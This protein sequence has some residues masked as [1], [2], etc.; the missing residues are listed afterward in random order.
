MHAGY[1]CRHTGVC[2]T[3]GWDI[4]ADWTLSATLAGHFGGSRGQLFA[5]SGSPAGP[6]VLARATGGA[7][8]LY[9]AGH[10]G[11]GCAAHRELGEAR[12]PSVCRHFPRVVLRDRRGLFVT[13][14]H[15]CP[16]AAAL[17]VDP[18][19]LRIVTAPAT[20]TLDGHAEG[21]EAS[22]VLPPLLRPGMLIDDE[23]HDA[24]ERAA[25]DVLNDDLAPEQALARIRASTT[26]L[27]DWT[28]NRGPLAD[29]VVHGFERASRH[30]PAVPLPGC[31]PD[32]DLWSAVADTIPEGLARPDPPGPSL[33]W[34]DMRAVW[35]DQAAGVRRYLAARLFAS[36][37]AYDAGG[38]LAAVRA[39]D[40][41]AAVLR[42][43]I[44]R[45]CSAPG[46]ATPRD[47]FLTGVRAADLLI[48]HLAEHR[49][50][51]R[52]VEQST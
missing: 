19:P 6:A 15:Y 3:S 40:I 12:L 42:V 25:V 30:S 7:C 8:I 9:D 29:A 11:G 51:C 50:L 23:G 45:A 28:P 2:C 22:G 16:T 48:V 14:S 5:R 1:R 38:L 26:A 33:D 43:E 24:W 34:V 44:S 36:W 37:F 21:L 39:V 32:L 31:A 20:L 46:P 13:L 49:A 52:L 17:L 18:A 35:G 10:P 4:P 41:A 27:Q 47:R